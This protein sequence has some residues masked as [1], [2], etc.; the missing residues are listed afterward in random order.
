M[1]NI[2]RTNT[3]TCNHWPPRFLDLNLS[4]VVSSSAFAMDCRFV[5]SVVFA[6]YGK[7][8]VM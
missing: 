5:S 4:N 7:D 8:S 3:E 6:W 2:G 1:F